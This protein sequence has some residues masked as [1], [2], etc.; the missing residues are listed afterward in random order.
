MRLSQS[1]KKLLKLLK[2]KIT[3]TVIEKK[4]QQYSPY[5]LFLMEN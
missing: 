1:F 3:F 2:I 4:W 5:M